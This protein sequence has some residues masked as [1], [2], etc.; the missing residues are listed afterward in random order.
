MK[1]YIG[2]KVLKARPM[3][4]QEYVDYRGWDLPENENG[5]DEVYLVEYPI[6][7]DTVPN[8]PDHKGY[9]SMSPKSVFEKYYKELEGE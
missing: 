9:I 6:E 7:V 3:T 5:D 1:T 8:H 2:T 4:R